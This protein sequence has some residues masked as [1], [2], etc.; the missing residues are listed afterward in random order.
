MS[1]KDLNLALRLR[2]EGKS[3]TSGTARNVRDL[4][5]LP[6]AIRK[7]VA[8]NERLG[9]SQASLMRQQTSMGHQLGI[10][11]SGYHGLA[12]AIS[13]IVSLG[14]AAMFVRDTGNAQLLDTRL[15]GLTSSARE[16]N[17]VQ[18]YLFATADRLNTSYTTLA[19]SYSKI[20]NLQDVG[21]ITQSQ[22]IQILEGFANAAAKTGA[23]NEQLKQSLFGMTQ[24]MTTGVLKAEELNQVTEPLPGLLQKLDKAA[25]TAAGGFRHMVND[26]KV[27]SQMFKRY[28]IKALNEYAG[29]AEATEG[30][31]NA[32]FAEMGNEYQRLIR[33]YEKPVNFAVT[34][35]VSVIKS[36]MVELRE[37]KSLVEGLT[38][39][40]TALAIVL[41][42]KLVGSAAQSATAFASQAISKNRAL[43][44]SL[45]L[46][47]QEQRSAVI[48]HKAAVQAQQFAQHQLNVARTTEL[49]SRAIAQLAIANQRAV[50]TQATLTAATNTYTAAASR[51]SVAARAASG[52]MALMGGPVGAAMMAGL[53][54]AYF[55]TQ[56][57]TGARS[58][59]ELKGRVDE[60]AG[61]FDKLTTKAR[62]AR[63]VEV[64][65]TFEST[66]EQIQKA[67]QEIKQLKH[68]V[69]NGILISNNSI[70]GV[71]QMARLSLSK[72]QIKE[73]NE[74]ITLQEAQVE[75]LV[76]EQNRLLELQKKLKAEIAKPEPKLEG[77]KPE[78]TAQSELPE[79]IKRLQASLLSEEA[80]LKHSYNKRKKMVETARDNDAANTNKYNAILKQ[81]EA[82]YS[83]DLIQL[84]EKKEAEK[85][86]IQNQ[87]ERKRKNDQRA[88]LENRI[89]QVKGFA[90]RE[91]LEAYNSTLQVEQA[92]QQAR[93]D[94][95][96]R[97]QLGLAANDDAGEIK[98]NTDNEIRDLERQQELLAAEGFQ[99]EMEKREWD[100]QE[101]L[102][103]LKTKNTGALQQHLVQFAN[104]E[105]KNAAEKSDAVLGLGAAGL[106]A[107][108]Q[109]SKTAFKMYKAFAISQA[110]I[111][112]YESAT[113]AYAA[114][115]PIPVVGPALGAAAAA[116]A[117]AMGMAQVR[118]IKAQ[119][120]AGIAHGG[121]DYVPNES[122]Y[123]L[124]RGERVLSPKQNVE[125]SSMA[126]HYNAG[127][128]QGNAGPINFNITNQIVVQGGADEASSNRVGQ[129]IGKQITALIVKDIQEN[130]V[131][132]KSIRSA[133]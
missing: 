124:Q 9:A 103:Q 83:D 56:G 125:I 36:A 90:N 30:K 101:R 105:K 62:A 98:Y 123:L 52:A 108:G 45:A 27:T 99:S 78:V 29:A 67:K 46:A 57:D 12:G 72:N 2:Y 44:A 81:L 31:I 126:R 64:N 3:V 61:G 26:G 117:V 79:N 111:K 54:I 17:A 47:A 8:A 69:E 89:A 20:L 85:T 53:A 88:A 76:A 115:S 107:L 11:Q 22:G 73:S 34:N 113:G 132:I 77:K 121:L 10:L 33:E 66:S 86:R 60:L 116:A 58:A 119:Q 112:T 74:K 109:Q 42:S 41:G 131:I 70:F 35:V 28:L 51:A 87:A 120:P 129:D 110:L 21:I 80:A 19:D 82:K 16:Y 50:A 49:R 18:N 128:R 48:Q 25:G 40:A 102:M 5:Q 127:E 104:W 39:S 122:T 59:S 75:K 130:G 32:S 43:Q 37:N 114:L 92:R 63:L 4:N 95:K 15:R 55:A 106:Q 97:G 133:A 100:H 68:E 23:G 1:N 96:R 91:A 84:K 93:I 38:T 6:V 7:Q 65:R 14:S 94:A 118:Q 13:G 24:G 71:G